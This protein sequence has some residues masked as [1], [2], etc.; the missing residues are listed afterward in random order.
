MNATSGARRIIRVDGVLDASAADRLARA[1]ADGTPDADVAIDLSHVRA[2]DDFAVMMLGRTL[3][4]R[5]HVTIQGLR[6]HHV[7]LLRYLGLGDG[8]GARA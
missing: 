8:D 4:A 7:R 1:L 6:Q 5:G 2:F 3:S